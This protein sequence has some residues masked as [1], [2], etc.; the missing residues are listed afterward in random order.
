[1]VD[2]NQPNDFVRYRDYYRGEHYGLPTWTYIATYYATAPATA[3]TMDDD[4]KPQDMD[5]FGIGYERILT[6]KLSIGISYMHRAWKQ[7]I[8]DYD[9]DGD[10][11]WHF[12]NET[13]FHT[14]DT[15][16]GKTFRKY[17]AVIVTAAAPAMPRI[18][19]EQ[20][21]TGHGRMV[22]PVGSRISQSLIAVR[23]KGGSWTQEEICSCVFVPLL[24]KY[25]WETPAP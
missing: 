7:K 5:E 17:D 8:E 10:G 24:G 6:N 2:N 4:L 23:R 20:L 16:W 11:A 21:N 13:D 3:T 22:V 14:L 18:L 19:L 25:G 12:A 1:M 15:S 9:P